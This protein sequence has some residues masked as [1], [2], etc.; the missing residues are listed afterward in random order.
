MAV[1]RAV[2]VA[3]ADAHQPTTA[4]ATATATVTAT[5]TATATANVTAATTDAARC[6]QAPPPKPV[7]HHLIANQSFSSGVT[8]LI[9]LGTTF[10]LIIDD[11]ER[12]YSDQ[13]R[14]FEALW[15]LVNRGGIYFLEGLEKSRSEKGMVREVLGWAEHLLNEGGFKWTDWKTKMPEGLLSVHCQGGVC[16]MRK[17]Y[18]T[19]EKGK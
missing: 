3:V 12:P 19:R 5:T 17:E 1:A 10:D 8:T 9:H 2:A 18:Q 4:T 14:T 16:G 6:V 7:F 11:G 15:P 13:K